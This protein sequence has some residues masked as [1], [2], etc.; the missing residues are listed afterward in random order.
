MQVGGTQA[1]REGVG[2][3]GG[4]FFHLSTREVHRPRSDGTMAM[5]LA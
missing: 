4:C 5:G 3:T 2:K 1:P